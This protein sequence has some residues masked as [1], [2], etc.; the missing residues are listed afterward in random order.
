[1]SQPWSLW[2]D[3]VR[4]LTFQMGGPVVQQIS[5]HAI[6]EIAM[7]KTLVLE[8]R[9]ADL[10]QKLQAHA[11]ESQYNRDRLLA[12][13]A[14]A[15]HTTIRLKE[16]EAENKALKER[17]EALEKL[18]QSLVEPKPPTIITREQK[19]ECEEEILAP[20]FLNGKMYYRSYLNEVFGYDKDGEI[21]WVGMYLPDEDRIDTTAPEPEWE[22]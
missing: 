13:G 8:D 7:A 9:V 1:M 5:P 3:Y 10:D 2:K 21:M 20:V 18:V 15:A 22:K 14:V 11:D 19:V 16:V 12:V 6:T 17:L 4:S